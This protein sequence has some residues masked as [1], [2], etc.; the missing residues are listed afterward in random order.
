MKTVMLSVTYD[1]PCNL[2]VMLRV[3]MLN[4]IMLSVVIMNDIMLSVVIMNVIH[5]EF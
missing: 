3:C 2:T 1:E 5:A 4:G